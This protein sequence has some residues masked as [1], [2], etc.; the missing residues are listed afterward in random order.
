MIKE[1]IYQAQFACQEHDPDR[2]TR[3]TKILGDQCNG[4]TWCNGTA[5]PALVEGD[6]PKCA[7][8]KPATLWIKYK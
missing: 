1:F 4:K 8:G 5:C 3:H 7:G 2:M 6:D